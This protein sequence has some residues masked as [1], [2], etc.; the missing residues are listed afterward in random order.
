MYSW[1]MIMRKK[2]KIKLVGIKKRKSMTQAY[3]ENENP[4][5]PNRTVEPMTFLLL[6][7]YRRIVGAKVISKVHGFTELKETNGC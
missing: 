5:A 6:L 2:T 1:G 3:S 7:S 4:I